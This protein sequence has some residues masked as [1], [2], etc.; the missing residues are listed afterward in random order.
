MY[1][2]HLLKN[3]ALGINSPISISRPQYMTLS[4]DQVFHWILS[5]SV[6]ESGFRMTV[7]LLQKKA[8]LGL[9]LVHH[10]PAGHID[11]GGFQG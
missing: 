5:T 4:G 1:V 8:P 10:R 3:P 11:E 6:E 7:V 9:N 2:T